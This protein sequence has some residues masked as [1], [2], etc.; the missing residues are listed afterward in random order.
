MAPRACAAPRSADAV[1]AA[2]TGRARSG[3]SLARRPRPTAGAGQGPAAPGGRDAGGGRAP[4]RRTSAPSWSAQGP[5][6]SRGCASRWRRLGRCVWPCG[7]GARREHSVG[8]GGLWRCGGGGSASCARRGRALVPVVDAR[9]GQVFFG[10]Y[11]AVGRREIGS[12]WVRRAPLRRSA[13]RAASGASAWRPESRR[14]RGGRRGRALVGELPEG[15]RFVERSGAGRVPG[16]R[17]GAGSEEPGGAAA[18][19]P[20]LDAVARRGAGSRPGSAPRSR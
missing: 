14:S 20:R 8:P 11:E 2:E 9:R 10:V 4:S 16:R 15:V 3:R 13:I 5:A 18:G 17:A 7:T 6:L 19:E 1:A 12:D